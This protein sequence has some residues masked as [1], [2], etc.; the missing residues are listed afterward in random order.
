MVV[1]HPSEDSRPFWLL[2]LCLSVL[3]WASLLLLH[4]S[5][6]GR[7]LHNEEWK[8]LGLADAICSQMPG[9]YWLAPALYASGW[10]LMTAA[11]MLPTAL[12][13]IRTFDR[14]TAAHQDR[15][16]LH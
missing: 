4:A 16:T 2:A 8:G 3:A 13:L 5:P 7:Y 15:A 12:P 9:G 14:M 1:E 10:V 6:Y 11:M